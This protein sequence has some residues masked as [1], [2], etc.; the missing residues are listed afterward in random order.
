MKFLIAIFLISFSVSAQEIKLEN[1]MLVP[2]NS[3]ENNSNMTI[4]D[5]NVIL[6]MKEDKS[7]IARKKSYK[8]IIEKTLSGEKFLIFK[9]K[10]EVKVC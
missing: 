4:E 1:D 5:V 10:R 8:N 2:S 9:A 6:L 3:I 7:S